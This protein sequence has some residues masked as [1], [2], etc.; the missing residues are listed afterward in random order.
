MA[1]TQQKQERPESDGLSRRRFL[2][3]AA[4]TMLAM[5][6]MSTL[7]PGCTSDQVERTSGPTPTYLLPDEGG[8][9]TFSGAHVGREP[10][11][12]GSVRVGNFG[13]FTFESSAVKTLRPDVFQPGHFSLFDLVAYLGERGDIALDYHFDE[14]IDT[15]VI[16]TIDGRP[17]W[18][19]DAHYAAGWF[20]S[21]VFRMDKYPYKDGTQLRLF[22]THED[23]LE[24]IYRSFEEESERLEQ[25]NGQVIV[26][27]VQIRAPSGTWTFQDVVVTPHDVRA[28]LFRPGIETALDILL[29]LAEQGEFSSLGLT[30]YDRIG[31]AEPLDSYFVEQVNDSR[32]AGGCGFVYE[33]GPEQF[34]GFSGTHIHIPSDARVIRSPEYALWFWICQ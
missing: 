19:Y 3:Q 20:E 7:L 30:W 12:G 29:S 28:D 6:G 32:S 34:S 8:S 13:T 27:R 9:W 10:E 33:S 24:A 22:A 18:W 4:C 17:A 14:R 26:P 5:G 1:E 31:S 23:R 15:H 2:R 25:N 16:D 11:G 21:N